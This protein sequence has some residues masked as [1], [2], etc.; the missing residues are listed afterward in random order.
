MEIM[1]KVKAR[2]IIQN[3]KFTFKRTA[4]IFMQSPDGSG[5]ADTSDVDLDL[6][7]QY[8]NTALNYEERELA[9]AL[10]QIRNRWNFKQPW[11]YYDYDEHFNYVSKDAQKRFVSEWIDDLEAEADIAHN[12]IQEYEAQKEAEEEE[13]KTQQDNLEKE[14]R[15][16]RQ[17]LQRLISRRL[18]AGKLIDINVPRI[19]KVITRGSINVLERLISKVKGEY[20]YLVGRGFA[21]KVAS[22]IIDILD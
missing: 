7:G 15:Q 17:N 1:G 10:E 8:E 19:P 22:A 3:F 5:I 4:E 2:Q 12:L 11:L 20:R 21:G 9:M 14:Y 13:K 6:I 16:K 18:K